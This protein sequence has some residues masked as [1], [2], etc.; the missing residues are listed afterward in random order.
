MTFNLRQLDNLSYDEVEPILDDYIQGA[1]NEFVNSPEGEDHLKT[2]PSG[3]SWIGSF[4][5][6]GYNYGETT[7]PRMTKGDVQTLME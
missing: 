7:L 3:G 1:I 5:E 4:I 6:L 2:Y